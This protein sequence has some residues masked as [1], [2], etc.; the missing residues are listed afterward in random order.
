MQV[1]TD[2]QGRARVPASAAAPIPLYFLLA[3]RH[4]QPQLLLADGLG[5]WLFLVTRLAI[6]LTSFRSRLSPRRSLDQS[7]PRGNR[8]L[9][10]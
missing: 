2:R 5:V 6:S 4:P 10:G 8:S 7:G 9:L 3:G 1:L